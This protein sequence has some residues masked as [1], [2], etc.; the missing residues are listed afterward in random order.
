[1]DEQEALVTAIL[2]LPRIRNRLVVLCEGDLIPLESRGARSPQMNGRLDQMPDSNFYKGCVPRDWHSHR[3]PQFFNCGGRSQV[4]Y[5]YSRLIERHQMNPNSTY[6]TPEK[7]YAL[8]DLDIQGDR[9]PEGYPWQTS[10]DV[11]TALYQ[12][13]AINGVPDNDHRIWVLSLIHI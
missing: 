12:D 10:E 2:A 9:M 1:M 13:G 4:L 8:V 11:H 6:L 3:L 5:V 7:L